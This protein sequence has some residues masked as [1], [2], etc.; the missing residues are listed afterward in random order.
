MGE[1]DVV[2]HAPA[3][4]QPQAAPAAADPWSVV[5]HDPAP[6]QTAPAT[7]YRLADRA[8][9][10]KADDEVIRK[11]GLDPALIKSS[12]LYVPGHLADTANDTSPATFGKMF[13]GAAES[14]YSL[15]AGIMQL[16]LHGANK[17]G[18]ASDADVQYNDL[19]DKVQRASYLAKVGGDPSR[20]GEFAGNLMVPIPGG[21][22][23]TLIGAVAK[24]ALTGAA[25]S[26]AQ[27]VDVQP[28]GDYWGPKAQQAA[29]GAVLGGATGGVVGGVTRGVG[30]LINAR[31]VQLPEEIA[32]ANAE[33]AAADAAAARTGA[34]QG[35]TGETARLQGALQGTPFEGA[36]DVGRVAQAGGPGAKAAQALLQAQMIAA[37][38]PDQI[39]KASLAL[40]NWRTGQ[41]ANAL[42]NTVGK[43]ATK[44]DM[45]DVPLDQ[46]EIA[47]SKAIKEAQSAGHPDTG[48]IGTLKSFQKN[49][50]AGA[51]GADELVDNSYG[52]IRRLHSE[53]GDAIAEERSGG[54]QVSGN[55]AS[56]LLQTVRDAMDTDLRQYTAQG[57]PELQRAADTADRYFAQ[58]RVPFNAPDIR[59]AVQYNAAGST[60][61]AEA[62]KIFDKFIQAGS[63]DKAQRYFNALDPRGRAAVQYQMAVDAMNQATD[64]ARSTFDPEKFFNGLDKMQDAHG[65]FFKGPDKAAMDGLKNLAQQAV[66]ASDKATAEAQAAAQIKPPKMSDPGSLP[67]T[68]LGAGA[69]GFGLAATGHP[70]AA[71]ISTAAGLAIMARRL[72]LTDAGRR[73]LAAASDLPPGSPKLAYWLDAAQ[74]LV[75]AA[76]ARPASAP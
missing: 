67:L 23:K 50:G 59:N 4:A 72:M 28:G 8:V 32:A 70:V 14:V 25:L 18:L 24:G 12:H 53:L 44:Y 10:E 17:L 63:G 26:A 45:G 22:A 16:V 36:A 38:T 74:R 9:A 43:L 49:I 62:D 64:H 41:Q 51:D 31:T 5:S 57:P 35:V 73:I 3:T 15:P 56:R 2:S 34:Q 42:Y 76:A 61:A 65:V 37:K 47:L 52:R 11:Y 54:Q 71:S 75:P 7:S 30:K 68:L 1:W 27:P 46:S 58:T 29:A 6:A 60:T 66:L 40:T 13:Q 48:L 39:Q 55:A 33:K 19:A 20:L 21:A 69:G